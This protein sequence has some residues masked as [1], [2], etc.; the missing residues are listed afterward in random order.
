MN[1]A[2]VLVLSVFA[3]ITFFCVGNIY[4]LEMERRRANVDLV[5][6][7][8]IK[9][10]ILN[11]DEWKLILTHIITHKIEELDFDPEQQAEMRGRINDF[12]NKTID[13]FEAKFYEEK[14]ES[15]GGLLQSGITSLTGI[16]DKVIREVPFFTD[17]I[18][19]FINREENKSKAKEFVLEKF[20]EY[21][22]KTFSQV[23]YTEHNLI[24]ARYG[25]GDRKDTIYGLT[26]EIAEKKDRARI[27]YSTLFAVIFACLLWLLLVPS[28]TKTEFSLISLI[29]LCLLVA[30]LLLPMLE[31][32]ARVQDISFS[33]MGESI[34]FSDQVIY[35]R[36][37]SILEVV[38]LMLSQGKT[39][40][41]MVGIL[42]LTFSVLFPVSK[43]IGSVLYMF[44]DRM[45]NSRFIQFLVFKLGKWSMADVLVVVIFMSFIGFRS[46]LSEQL[47]QVEQLSPTI[48]I[49]STNK[50]SLQLGF[51]I[52]TAFVVL[53]LSIAQHI[54]HLGP[55]PPRS[56]IKPR[57]KLSDN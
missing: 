12:L 56:D 21:T 46:I 3:L 30:G 57:P 54:Q 33:L 52:F 20:T 26:Q 31:I 22:D 42:V 25:Y 23:D 11:I 24:L 9:Y 6:L 49:L 15:L 51:F 5:E 29:S 16:F 43:I 44:S 19:K 2:R 41:A 36:S 35:Y 32:D 10:G 37:K 27:Y 8:K 13:Q 45:K 1:Y 47:N 7:S 38:N 48:E 34:C 14:K 28:L 39:D 40:I 53:S 50:S 18:M 55:V 4:T 17:E